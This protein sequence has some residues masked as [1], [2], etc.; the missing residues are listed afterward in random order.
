MDLTAGV[1]LL[2]GHAEADSLRY[3]QRLLLDGVSRVPSTE[4]VAPKA[5]SISTTAAG[6]SAA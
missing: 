2:V 5:P 1:N 6:S 4:T 3:G